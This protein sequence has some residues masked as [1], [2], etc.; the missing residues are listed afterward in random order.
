[1]KYSLHNKL[2]LFLLLALLGFGAVSA[3]AQNTAGVKPGIVHVKFKP[4][5]ATTLSS[6]SVSKTKSGYARTGMS[7]FDAVAA[8]YRAVEI[9]PLFIAKPG[10]EEAHRRHGLHLWYEVTIDYSASV[11]S[12]VSD[13]SHLSDVAIA[14]PVYEKSF[15]EPADFTEAPPMGTSNAPMNDP[16]LGQQWHYE[17]DGS[18]NGIVEADVNLFEAWET[19]TGSDEVIVS[20]HDQ[21]V[22]ASHEDLAANMWVNELE[23]NGEPG[24]D[25]DFNGYVD[26]IYGYDFVNNSGNVPAEDHGTHVAGTVSAVNNNGI[27]VAGVAGG[28]GANDGAKIMTMKAIGGN[29]AA[30]FA[31][32]ADNGAV[33]SQNSWTYTIPN[34]YEQ[35]VLDA[36]DYFIA[37]AGSFA[38]SPMK[39]GIVIFAA[40]NYNSTATYWPEAYESVMA[41]ASLGR[42]NQK[43]YYSNYAP[44]VDIAA[45]GGDQSTIYG[46]SSGGVLSTLPGNNYGFYQGTSMACPHVSGI[47]ALVVAAHGSDTFTNDDLWTHLITGTKDIYEYNPSYEGMLG[48]GYI[49]AALAVATNNGIAP[50]II[51]DFAVN[52][53]SQDF[54]DVQWTSVSDS[55]DGG[56]FGY[57]IYYDQDS[58]DVAQKNAAASVV[59]NDKSLAGN[60]LSKTIENLLPETKYYFAI[61]AFDRWG[62]KADLSTIISAT[63]TDAPEIAFDVASLAMTLDNTNSHVSSD[64]FNVINNAEGALKWNAKIRQTNA[65]NLSTSGISYPQKSGQPIGVS[66]ETVET[67]ESPEAGT[68]D[69]DNDFENKYWRVGQDGGS[70]FIIGDEDTSIPN[71]AAMRYQVSDPEGFN[72]TR[73]EQFMNLNRNVYPEGVLEIFQGATMDKENLVLVQEFTGH[74]YDGGGY[75]TVTLDHQLFFESGE[76]FWVVFHMPAGIQYPL[77]IGQ[78]DPT[79]PNSSDDCFMSFDVGETWVPLEEALQDGNWVWKQELQSTVQPIHEYLTLSVQEGVTP[80]LDQQ[81]IT[82]NADGTDLINGTYYASA[83]FYSNDDTHRVAEVELTVNVNDHRPS[84]QS[85]SLVDM[86]STFVGI[87]KT[88]EIELANS[89]LGVFKV[90]KTASTFNNADF[91]I[92][93]WPGSQWSPRVDAL[94]S[95][96][97]EVTFTPSVAG[98]VN[99]TLTL[100][101]DK[102]NQHVVNVSG[103]GTAPS[104]IDIPISSADFTMAIGDV[105]SGSFDIVNNGDYPLEYFLPRY[106]T[107]ED[108]L[109]VPATGN[110]FGYYWEHS[111]D[112][113][114][115]ITYDWEDISSTGED[116]TD[117]WSTTG[118]TFYETDLGFEF[119]LFKQV[120]EKLYITEF[121]VLTTHTDIGVVGNGINPGSEHQNVQISSLNRRLRLEYGGNIYVQRKSGRLIIQYDNVRLSSSS[122]TSWTFQTI[123]HSNGDVVTNYQDVPSSSYYAGATLAM[124]DPD[125]VYGFVAYD[126]SSSTETPNA[127]LTDMTSIRMFSA[128]VNAIE[129]ISSTSGVVPVGGTET[130]NFDVNAANLIEGNWY[131]RL[132]VAS[133]DTDE[134]YST[135]TANINVN[136]GGT[137]DLVMSETSINMGSIFQGDSTGHILEIKNSGS[138]AVD[139]DAATLANGD[140]ELVHDGFPF[141]LKAKTSYFISVGHNGLAQGTFNDVLTFDFSDGSQETVDL[142]I[143]VGPAPGLTITTDP[144]DYALNVGETVPHTLSIENTGAAELEYTVSGTE[145]AYFNDETAAPSAVELPIN[146]YEWKTTFEDGSVGYNWEE[147]IQN[148]EQLDNG[149]N[150][151]W[152]KKALPF[153]FNYYGKTY[154]SIYIHSNG[155]IT[156]SDQTDVE[157]GFADIQFGMPDPGLVNNVISPYWFRGHYRYYENEEDRYQVGTFYKEYED[158]VVVEY[159]NVA[160]PQGSEFMGVQAIIYKNGNI[161]FQYKLMYPASRMHFGTVGIENEDGTLGEQVVVFDIFLE[162]KTAVIFSPANKRTLAAGESVD[163]DMT[164][165]ANY[166]NGGTYNADLLI[167]SNVPGQENA[168]VPAQLVVT[169]QGQP[170]GPTEV[171]FGD[172]VAETLPNGNPVTH[173]FEFFVS[174][175]GS[176]DL[177]FTTGDL[178]IG[179]EY[180]LVK[181]DE[182]C[183]FWGCNEILTPVDGAF[184]LELGPG[185]EQ[186]FRIT[187]NTRIEAYEAKDTIVFD[188]GLITELRIPVY[189]NVFLP[190]VLDIDNDS[191]HFEANSSEF[192]GTGVITLDNSTG[193]GELVYELGLDYN[194]QGVTMAQVMNSNAQPEGQL[195]QTSVEGTSTPMGTSNF[196]RTLG[197][198]SDEN[199]TF[200]GFGAGSA[201]STTTRFNAGAEGFNLSH[202]STYFS[203]ENSTSSRIVVEVYAGKDIYDAVKI[204]EAEYTHES[205]PSFQGF[206]NIPLE[207]TLKLYPH[208]TFFVTI[209]YPFGIGFPQGINNVEDIP[210]TF[211]YQSGSFWYDMQTSGFSGLGWNVKALEETYEETGWIEL[212]ATG[213]VAA[214]ETGSITIDVHAANIDL[215]DVA[216]SVVINSN[217]PYNPIETAS[218][219]MHLN[220]APVFA[221]GETTYEVNETETLEFTV[222]ATDVEGESITYALVDSPAG[223]TLTEESEEA[224]ISFTPDYEGAGSYNFAVQATDSN[225]GSSFFNVEVV[226]VDVNRT[227]EATSMSDMEL[228]VDAANYIIEAS[229]IFNDP[230]L[231][232]LNYR[233]V[234]EDATIA[235]A[236]ASDTQFMLD[237]ATE[238]ETLV[239]FFATDDR[240]EEVSVSIILTVTSQA[241]QAPTASSMEDLVLVIGEPHAIDPA[242][243]FTDAEGDEMSFRVESSNETAIEVSLVDGTFEILP[244]HVGTATITLFA[245]DNLHEEVSVSFEVSA[246]YVLGIGDE[247]IKQLSV[248]PNPVIDR[249]MINV[250][251]SGE[252]QVRL[253][254]STGT[255]IMAKTMTVDNQSATIDM[256]QM[257]AGIYILEVSNEDQKLTR[258]IIKK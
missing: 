161:K 86:G 184:T 29:M 254:T 52:T 110:S 135:F 154:D 227:P 77:G 82:V 35:A 65:Y 155:L 221:A 3:L 17:N 234:A 73:I 16:G 70:I 54:V 8:N 169:G 252:Y 237:P 223:M 213:S 250:D 124:E 194:R 1:M 119:P 245:T 40:G 85:A 160:S 46:G 240:S 81:E 248:Y 196:N 24:V 187:L 10:K 157:L 206:V 178:A 79:L 177:T 190:P 224:H 211:L 163:L 41:V 189:A 225:G 188:E 76:V 97:I 44:W 121:G 45:P 94:D 11:L 56:V 107:K 22:D 174:N 57:E 72:L 69:Y 214:G 87:S 2:R 138:K 166:L 75:K 172:I 246:D 236:Y 180:E 53:I 15:V 153:S 167:Q 158:Y 23:M 182:L 126:V 228:S 128:G 193:Q 222:A 30:S 51:S 113:G 91:E 127:D 49:D 122:S 181:L 98:N 257:K 244:V 115:S 186:Q 9:K 197:Y 55:D 152:H 74:S 185:D 173:D 123:V 12:S 232:Q 112:A 198:G 48:V 101:D 215:A 42:S 116:I 117:Y 61:S 114:A 68:S 6:M 89:G 170:S 37:E 151:E 207:E 90:D 230:D 204:A 99:G 136:A 134:P 43:A 33:I 255:T 209:R 137:I 130:I 231:D 31:Y 179:E 253:H 183:N 199:N 217:D 108:V 84:L 96:V 156:L 144:I 133:N 32:A 78:E 238:G 26:D 100:N 59:I 212:T 66:K 249:L 95:D 218:V 58:L 106:E 258:R 146:D 171:N 205:E 109:L 243:V 202:I 34:V 164:I 142:A 203:S 102:G 235:Q 247:L 140:F 201:M 216:A 229:S 162:D 125:K 150:S 147:L 64:V 175:S 25:D 88:I 145:W 111:G 256:S 226:V 28:S 242:T 39:G 104:E 176:G 149:I 159:A 4:G 241:N 219:S 67:S 7:A 165:D 36:I 220:Q 191:F 139:I 18:N 14:E 208:E 83:V 200:L 60:S 195:T 148:G 103:V 233:V 50:E 38:G 80:G 71:S 47:A 5:M 118:E 192:T 210:N 92:T 239:T 120:F 62:N 105:A 168:I 132:I 13:F 19:T 129:N 141:E 143:E 20:V 63:T 251:Q 93:S 27:G 131:Q 21:G